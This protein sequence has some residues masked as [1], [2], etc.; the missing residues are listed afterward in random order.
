VRTRTSIAV[1]I[2]ALALALPAA[3]QACEGAG[4]EPWELRIEQADETVLCLINQSR[5]AAGVRPVRVDGRLGRAARKHSNSMDRRNFFA[6]TSPS[7]SDPANRARRAGYMAGASS[8][9][10]AEIIRWGAAD[11]GTPK[12]AVAAWMNSPGHRAQLLSGRFRHVGVGV[13][14]GSPAGNGSDAAI[15]TAVFGDRSG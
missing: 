6:H 15:Y 2:T 1:G 9:A 3:A 14:Y 12:S 11:F 8:W 7:G 13:R 5:R 4:A 10:V